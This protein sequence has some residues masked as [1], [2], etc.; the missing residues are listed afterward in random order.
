MAALASGDM[1]STKQII[2][3][4]TRFNIDREGIGTKSLVNV[5]SSENKT[6]GRGYNA[7]LA[8]YA[9]HPSKVAEDIGGFDIGEALVTAIGTTLMG[10][11]FSRRFG[12][13]DGFI[14]PIINSAASTMGFEK[15]FKTVPSEGGDIDGEK[16]SGTANNKGDNKVHSDSSNS[17]KDSVAKKEKIGKLKTATWKTALVAGA[18]YGLYE[19]YERM[20]IIILYSS[21]QNNTPIERFCRIDIIHPPEPT[22]FA[23]IYVGE[24]WRETCVVKLCHHNLSKTYFNGA[25]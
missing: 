7:N 12:A 4:G 24:A 11:A 5:D 8:G 25:D 2:A 17:D 15:P 20:T 19:G 6:V 14:K 18:T 21:R 10:D 23:C 9:A 22:R 16:T 13:K 3:G 1:E